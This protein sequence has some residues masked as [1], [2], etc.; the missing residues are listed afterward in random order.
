M[1]VTNNYTTALFFS[2]LPRFFVYDTTAFKGGA[3]GSGVSKVET[4]G[5]VASGGETS[6]GGTNVGSAMGGGGTS[7]DTVI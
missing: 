1:D 5:G 3:S 7:R 2:V 4:I 6:G